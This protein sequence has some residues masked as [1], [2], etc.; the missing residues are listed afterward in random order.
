M[1]LS[2]NQPVTLE[3]SGLSEVREMNAMCED[4]VSG[5]VS[6]VPS[7]PELSPL[8]VGM[9]M[10]DEYERTLSPTEKDLARQ[11]SEF[12][13][14]EEVSA[15]KFPF[16]MSNTDDVLS[17]KSAV[18]NLLRQTEVN[19]LQNQFRKSQ[20]SSLGDQRKNRRRNTH[21]FKT[22]IC[23]RWKELG[24][25][26]YGEKCCFAHGLRELRK[27][28]VKHKNLKN[29]TYK[30][31]L[32]G[33][34]PHGSPCRFSHVFQHRIS[35]KPNGVF[36]RRNKIPGW[37]GRYGYDYGDYSLRSLRGMGMNTHGGIRGT[38]YRQ[39]PCDY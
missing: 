35:D 18:S 17:C 30:N 27:R 39:W 37:T 15:S 5:N 34:F 14:N 29:I 21:L 2:S 36:S 16:S 28:P 13:L 10:S 1:S 6:D 7:S 26:P 32:A 4:F 9:S 25:C 12:S 8:V 11:L 24:Y 33:C 23:N 19:L 20:F 3:A 31:G 38:A 22:K